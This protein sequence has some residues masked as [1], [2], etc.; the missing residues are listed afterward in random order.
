MSVGDVRQKYLPAGV[1]GDGDFQ[2]ERSLLGAG[3]IA[4]DFAVDGI[5]LAAGVSDAV[6]KQGMKNDLME[7]GGSRKG[8]DACDFAVDP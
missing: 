7:A 3:P 8:V 5:V 4:G 1:G 2:G 6:I